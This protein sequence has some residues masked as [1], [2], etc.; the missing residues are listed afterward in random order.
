MN[1][2]EISARA[3]RDLIRILTLVGRSNRTAVPRLRAAAEKT[4]RQLAAMPGVGESYDSGDPNL[5]PIRR[6]VVTGYRN[7]LVYYAPIEGGIRVL[8]VI[9]S[10]REPEDLVETEDFE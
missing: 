1:G 3:G 7:Y 6:C 5:G 2:V 9:H 8:R 10:A 4:F